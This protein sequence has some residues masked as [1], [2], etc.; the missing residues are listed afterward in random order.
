MAAAIF[1]LEISS[2]STVS[3]APSANFTLDASWANRPRKSGRSNR[4]GIQ[5]FPCRQ[6][7]IAGRKS[8]DATTQL[9]VAKQNKP[10]PHLSRF[11]GPAFS[12]RARLG[13][14]NWRCPDCHWTFAVTAAAF[15]ER[16]I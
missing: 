9:G 2:T 4:L 1:S 16:T 8:V 5:V 12:A 11:P 14:S 15:A 3:L 6:I 13:R 10:Q 7:I